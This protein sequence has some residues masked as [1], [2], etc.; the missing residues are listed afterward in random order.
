MNRTALLAFAACFGVVSAASAYDSDPGYGPD[1]PWLQEGSHFEHGRWYGGRGDDG[2]YGANG[3]MLVPRYYRPTMRYYGNGYTVSY[4]FIPVFPTDYARGGSVGESS[5]FPTASTHMTV[6]QYEAFGNNLARITQ[7]DPHSGAPRTAVTSIIRKKTVTRSSRKGS[8]A[9]PD[10]VPTDAPAITP[11]SPAP[12][13]APAV[14]PTQEAP[15]APTAPAPAA[16][17]DASAPAPAK[18]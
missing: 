15:A 2:A 6:E 1:R 10:A 4:R 5:N 18:P 12:A 16:A 13:P 14:A 17:P 11:N 7:K 3:R 8:Q 9:S